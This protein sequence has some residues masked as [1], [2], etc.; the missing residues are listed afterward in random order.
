[1]DFIRE[2]QPDLI[3]TLIFLI[4]GIIQIFIAPIFA[5]KKEI[6]MR[7]RIGGILLAL[8]GVAFMVIRF[9]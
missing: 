8:L 6:V 2:W 1:M 5:S 3:L 7:W 4:G 9:I